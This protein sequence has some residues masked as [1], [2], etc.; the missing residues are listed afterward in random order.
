MWLQQPVAQG[1]PTGQK[2]IL[3]ARQLRRRVHSQM[4]RIYLLQRLPELEE[5][6]LKIAERLAWRSRDTL[7]ALIFEE[8]MCNM[9]CNKGKYNACIEETSI[10]ICQP[11][12]AEFYFYDALSRSETDQKKL[13]I[14]KGLFQA[15]SLQHNIDSVLKYTIFTPSTQAKKR[16]HKKVFGF[17]G[18]AAEFEKKINQT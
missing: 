5:Q 13:L 15:Y 4:S 11:D 3:I 2:L 16:L 12:S 8:W 6:E 18:T 10:G 7:S 9:L 14:Y 1:L 17:E